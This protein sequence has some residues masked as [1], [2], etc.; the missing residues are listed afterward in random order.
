[1]E[2][3]NVLQAMGLA[4]SAPPNSAALAPVEVK[5]DDLDLS[6]LRGAQ[7]LQDRLEQA[8][9]TAASIDGCPE[10]MAA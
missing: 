3:I 5:H 7:I 10:T 9:A 6:S 2:M 1:M 4:L 8:I